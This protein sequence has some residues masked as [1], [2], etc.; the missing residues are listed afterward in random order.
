MAT[1]DPPPPI[2]IVIPLAEI[3]PAPVLLLPQRPPHPNFWWALLWCF[4]FLV[5]QIGAQIAGSIFGVV[6]VLIGD[7]RTLRAVK[8]ASARHAPSQEIAEMLVGPATLSGAF[9]AQQLAAVFFALLA[10]RIVVGKQWPRHLAFRRPTLWHLL[11]ALLALPGMFV[12][13]SLVHEVASRLIPGF[14]YQQMVMETIEKL[15]FAV[16]LVTL[17][18]GPGFAEEMMLRGFIGRGL[19][20]RRGAVLGVFL[21]SLLFGALHLDPPHILTTFYMGLILHYVY[22]T[23]RSILLPMLMHAINNG[24]AVVAAKQVGPFATP[25]KVAWIERGW[26]PG[27]CCLMLAAVVWALYASRVRIGATHEGGW[28]P[29]FPGVECPPKQS[30][31]KVYACFHA[32]SALAV[33]VAAVLLLAALIHA[34][35]LP[36][37]TPL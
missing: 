28:Q 35:F 8:E 19:L 21:T 36:P 30:D 31:S 37:Q 16:A 11:L 5:F 33:A 20:A 6:G 23:G 29:A 13:T 3:E 34:Y 25:E 26:V 18:L 10:V 14:H 9:F 15:P 2:P 27:A 22:L 12:I 17:A 4:G 1:E 24:M 7:P 32:P